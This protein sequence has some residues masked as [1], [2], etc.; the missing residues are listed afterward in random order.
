MAFNNL[1]SIKGRITISG[2][3][4]KKICTYASQGLKSEQSKA[5]LGEL[6][7]TILS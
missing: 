4:V 2:F 7:P 1:F 5:G 3:M 6:Y